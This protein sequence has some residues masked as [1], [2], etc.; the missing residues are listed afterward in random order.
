M[1]AL[2]GVRS[3]W[4][5]FARKA[6]LARL[7]ASAASRARTS[8]PSTR[9]CSVMSRKTTT[10]LLECPLAS[11]SGLALALSQTAARPSAAGR[12]SSAL[13][14]D[15]PRIARLVGSSSAA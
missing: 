13:S 1:I 8:A 5:M 15:S 14:T 2:R 10:A 4:L 11:R 12:Y 3:S 6:L 7:A 9:F